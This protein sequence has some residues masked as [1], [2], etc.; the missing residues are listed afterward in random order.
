MNTTLKVFSIIR[1]VED[2][3][4]GGND[5][6][7]FKLCHFI[8]YKKSSKYYI[9]NAKRIY[10]DIEN[11]YYTTK[12]LVVYMLYKSMMANK[13]IDLFKIKGEVVRE[14]MKLFTKKTLNKDLEVLKSVAKNMEFKNIQ[15][16][17]DMKEDGT[18]IAFVL[19]KKE[20]I[21]PVFFIKNLNKNLTSESKDDIINVE[22]EQFKKIAKKIK[23]TL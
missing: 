3:V 7:L 6:D 13:R 14:T 20:L 5:I 9:T 17:F 16:F 8:R 18:N 4:K 1:N 21:S 22:F 19:T 11:G 23:E 10:N 2:F 15:D 12:E